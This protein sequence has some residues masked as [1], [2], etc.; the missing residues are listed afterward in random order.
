MI[1]R[2]T[3]RGENVRA[4]QSGLLLLGFQPGKVD[5]IF[6]LGTENAVEAFQNAHDL[7]TDGIAGF[8]TITAYNKALNDYQRLRQQT[9]TEVREARIDLNPEPE[10]TTPEPIEKLKWVKCPADKFEKRGGYTQTRL[11]EDTAVAYNKL[12]E[13]VHQLGGIVTSAGGKRSLTSKAGVNRS[14]KSMHYTGR[15]FDM[16]LPTG[17]INPETDPFILVQDEDSRYWTVWCV[18]SLSAERLSHLCLQYGIKNAGEMTLEG[19]YLSRGMV[20]TKEVTRVAFSFT[21]V[22]DS[23]GFDR[24][25][26]RRSFFGKKPKMGA[27]EWWHFQWETGLVVGKTTFGDEL[28]RVYTLAQAKKFVYW[29]QAKNCRW[30]VNWG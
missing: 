26:A 5:G 9:M 3:H 29:N 18:S 1:L 19:S 25:P 7:Y 2:R 15:A 28:L 23:F 8:D 21:E 10:S 30:G 13:T 4:L 17:L 11:R 24:I 22:A 12:Y 27:A 14:K 6:G 16:A 20:K